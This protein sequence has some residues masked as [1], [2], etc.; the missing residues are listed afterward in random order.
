MTFIVLHAVAAMA[1]LIM[2]LDLGGRAAANLALLP[3]ALRPWAILTHPFAM[4]NPLALGLTLL[5]AWTLGDWIERR[6]GAARLVMLYLAGNLAAGAAYAAYAALLSPA[7]AL[8]LAMPVGALAAWC[9]AACAGLRDEFVTVFGKLRSVAQVAGVSG[10]I[11]VA[12]VLF[13]GADSAAWIVAAIAAFGTGLLIDRFGDAVKVP[14]LF[15][16]TRRSRQASRGARRQSAMPGRHDLDGP[17]TRTTPAA[18]AEID[19]I[20]AKISRDGMESLT[21]SE[22]RKLEAARRERLNRR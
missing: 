7:E 17:A 11:V 9:A 21:D 5:A 16:E 15:G 4:A 10:A 13:R 8:A 22:R 12:L 2:Q 19:A 20:L 14:R 1:M 18:S 3:G 6:F